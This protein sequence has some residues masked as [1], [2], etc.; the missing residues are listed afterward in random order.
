MAAKI[1]TEEQRCRNLEKDEQIKDLQRKRL[2][3]KLQKELGKQSRRGA[4]IA[5]VIVVLV[6]FF[7]SQGV[8]HGPSFIA[9]QIPSKMRAKCEREGIFVHPQQQEGLVTSSDSEEDEE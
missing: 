6:V 7:P 9:I 2:E 4:D 5:M 8:S 3:L 1:A